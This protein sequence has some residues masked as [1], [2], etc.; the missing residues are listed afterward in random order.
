MCKFLRVKD[1]KR[2]RLVSKSW[3]DSF[4]PIL[5]ERTTV[6][7]VLDPPDH[8]EYE[9]LLSQK[10][11]YSDVVAKMAF[12]PV[13]IALVISDSYQFFLPPRDPE[14]FLSVKNLKYVFVMFL[15]EDQMEWKKDL[16]LKIIQNSAATLQKLK[17]LWD[18]ELAFRSLRGTVFPKLIELEAKYTEDEEYVNEEALENIGYAITES[19]PRLECLKMESRDLNEIAKMG[20]LPK[21]PL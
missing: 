20:F 21:F 15:V 2:C 12:S 4:T 11:K 18:D 10:E 7:I 16:V 17:F 9:D 6:R 5:K 14:I 8:D 3:N 13:N 1:V 19:F